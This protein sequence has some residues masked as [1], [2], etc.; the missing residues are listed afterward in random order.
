MQVVIMIP[1]NQFVKL[2]LHETLTLMG[3]F[4]FIY[5]FP[6]DSFC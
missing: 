4:L 1:I 5:I 3:F 6:V 2:V